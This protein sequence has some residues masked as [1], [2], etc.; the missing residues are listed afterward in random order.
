MRALTFALAVIASAVRASALAPASYSAEAGGGG[1]IPL[2]MGRAV[3][4]PMLSTS[5]SGPP[6]ELY[7]AAEALDLIGELYPAAAAGGFWDADSSS[8][9]YRV[10]P[11][12][13]GARELT[14]LVEGKIASIRDLQVPINVGTSS[15]STADLVNAA[16]RLNADHSWAGPDASH[17]HGVLADQLHM[18][19]RVSASEKLQELAARAAAAAGTSGRRSSSIRIRHG[20]SSARATPAGRKPGHRRRYRAGSVR[21]ATCLRARP[22]QTKWSRGEPTHA[23]RPRGFA[24]QR[25]QERR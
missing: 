25:R 17:V 11:G 19:L 12:A 10:V 14:T 5:E 21:H 7:E 20:S 18:M 3:A 15:V 16:D 23:D 6:L 1:G 22:A 24:C 9:T 13:P 2:R 4:P 8:Y